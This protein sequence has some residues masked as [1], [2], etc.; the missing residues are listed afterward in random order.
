MPILKKACI[1][2]EK[3][4]VNYDSLGYKSY[5]SIADFSLPERHLPSALQHLLGHDRGEF[6]LLLNKQ[7]FLIPK[8]PRDIAKEGGRTQA[9]P[10]L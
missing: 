10:S 5:S 6:Y 4:T 3:G 9:E 7:Y 8:L 2:T 1:D